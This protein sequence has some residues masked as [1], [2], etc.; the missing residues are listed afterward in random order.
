MPR[1]RQL[2]LTP[3]QG[4]E[5][6][7]LRDHA[8][9]PYVRERAAAL[10]KVAE[11]QPVRQVALQG[12]LRVHEPETVSTWIDRYRADGASGLRVK[13]GRGRKPAHFPPEL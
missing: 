8:A 9:Q 13:R 4:A 2:E 5:L 12:L 3:E 7:D 1:R 6:R 10:L 11:G